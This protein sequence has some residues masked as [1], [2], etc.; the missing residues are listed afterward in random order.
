MPKINKKL[1]NLSIKKV[2]FSTLYNI[3]FFTRR[4][5]KYISWKGM[6]SLVDPFNPNQKKR[7][8]LRPF[9]L[10]PPLWQWIK[11]EGENPNEPNLAFSWGD[12]LEIRVAKK[13]PVPW[14]MVLFL[15]EQAS[16]VYIYS[17]FLLLWHGKLFS[18]RSIQWM[19]ITKI[20]R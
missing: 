11:A 10:Y 12:F 3:Y 16:L 8:T 15:F 6:L 20:R 2:E 5:G 9:G 13:N 4:F 17:Y 7:A 1:S 18:G 19:N 14:L